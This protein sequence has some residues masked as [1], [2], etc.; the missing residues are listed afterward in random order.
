MGKGKLIFVAGISALAVFSGI[1]ASGSVCAD[2]VI[3]G[4]ACA[5]A[6]SCGNVV[7]DRD[8]YGS[9][10]GAAQLLK[11]ASVATS[12]L[13]LWEHDGAKTTIQWLFDSKG[14]QEI[15][16]ML[17]G[18][19]L[20]SAVK[21]L[22]V[23]TLKGKMYGMEI[24]RTDGTS[25]QFAWLDGYVF[26][27]DGNVYKAD[28]DFKSIGKYSWQDE[29]KISF[30]AFPN[31][32]YIAKDSNGWNQAFLEKSSRLK[33]EG[34]IMKN[35]RLDGNKLQV[36][37]INKTDETLCYGESFALQVK[38]GGYWYNIPSKETLCF[39]D[40]G[41]LSDAGSET[42]KTYDISA[43]G[44]LPAG[45]YRIVATGTSAVFNIS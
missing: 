17:N 37:L 3:A 35:A 38:K 30:A 33:Y 44:D 27:E 19:S 40:I 32:Y 11:D 26:M 34:M 15:V 6:A 23:N 10:S 7:Q 14:E 8:Y 24:G 21:D 1:F 41:I 13:A 29:D 12:A 18:I 43:Y 22:D 25:A 39:I 2:A 16:D 36:K 20:G 4:S 45:K 31:M 42:E 28:I 9:G 5:D